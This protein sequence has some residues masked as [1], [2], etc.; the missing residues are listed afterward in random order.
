MFDKGLVSCTYR[1][2]LNL[3]NKERAKLKYGKG[4][5]QMPHKI[6]EDIQRGNLQRVHADCN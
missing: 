4:S 2:H 3:N 5:E 6:G 1:E